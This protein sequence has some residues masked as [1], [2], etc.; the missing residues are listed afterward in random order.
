MEEIFFYSPSET[1]KRSNQFPKNGLECWINNTYFHLIKYSGQFKFNLVNEIPKNGI[2]VFHKGHFPSM[3]KPNKSQFFICVQSDHGRH[4]F[5]QYHICQNPCQLN[6]FGGS[7]KLILDL[8]L[9]FAKS[10]FI[11]SWSQPN[12]ITRDKK[13]KNAIKRVS[14]MGLEKNFPIEM[15]ENLKYDLNKKGIDFQ[16]EENYENWNDYCEIDIVLTIRSFKNERFYHKPYAKILNA[17]KAGCLVIAGN[18][19]SSI[20]FKNNYYPDL[21]IVSSYAELIFELDRIVSNPQETFNKVSKVHKMVES[22]FEEENIVSDYI[23]V[24]EKAVIDM[25]EWS[26]KSKKRWWFNAYRSL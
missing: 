16:L 9:S 13:R 21:P 4:K 20:Y 23:S 26:S 6:V 2:I 7:R 14:Y 1:P 8:L 22:K 3:L 25:K 15:R 18:E 10:F 11:R 12:L 19:S 17:L 5:A 24:F